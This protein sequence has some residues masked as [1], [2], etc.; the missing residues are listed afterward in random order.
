MINSITFP[1]RGGRQWSATFKGDVCIDVDV[2]AVKIED[3]AHGLA[4]VNRFCGQTEQP[5]SVGE[6]TLLFME[7]ALRRG[8]SARALRAIMLHD[9]PEALGVADC[10][11]ALK[12]QIAPATRNFETYLSS[13]LWVHFG[14][15]SSEWTYVWNAAMHTMDHTLG[16]WEAM[17][18]GFPCNRMVF[19]PYAACLPGLPLCLDPVT[20]TAEYLNQWRRL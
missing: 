2:G 12:K 10:H 16:N 9:A 8:Y 18:F 11:G 17:F 4:R 5:Y 3:I 13:C 1:L 14:Q 6:H 19:Y 15:T 7:W 20:V